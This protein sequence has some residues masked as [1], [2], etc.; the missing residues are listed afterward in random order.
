MLLFASAPPLVSAHQT[1]CGETQKHT[2]DTSEMTESA[3][4]ASV[5]LSRD[6]V[7]E[8]LWSDGLTDTPRYGTI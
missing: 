8:N 3:S 7:G 4:M 5:E 6:A 1:K 2:S